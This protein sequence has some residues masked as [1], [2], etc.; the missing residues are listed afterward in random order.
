MLSLWPV[1]KQ[2]YS[3]DHFGPFGLVTKKSR[4]QSSAIILNKRIVAK[5]NRIVIVSHAGTTLISSEFWY[6]SLWYQRQ[7]VQYFDD[8]DSS[9]KF[10]P[11]VKLLIGLYK[12]RFYLL[13]V[14]VFLFREL[15]FSFDCVCCVFRKC[16]AVCL[17]GW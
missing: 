8:F 7:C 9:C 12:R 17:K 6:I 3:K 14:P 2:F 13:F 5:L 11:I 15:W 4:M 10:A 16:W 1:I